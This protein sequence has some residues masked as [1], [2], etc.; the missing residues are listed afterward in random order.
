[1]SI[2]HLPSQFR[3]IAWNWTCQ[4]I[5]VDIVIPRSMHLRELH[6]ALNPHF[7]LPLPTA[8]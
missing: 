2:R 7:Q 1:M 8:R 4:A 5:K 6:L 3:E